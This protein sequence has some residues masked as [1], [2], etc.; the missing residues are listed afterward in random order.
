[1]RA[2]RRARNGDVVYLYLPLAHSFALLIQLI[3]ID[4]GGTVAYWGGDPKGVVGELMAVKPHYLPSV[5]RVFEKIY[6]LVTASGDPEKIKAATQ[7]GL[8]AR[9]LEA[10]GQPLPE[11][12]REHYEKADQ[13]LFANVRNVFGGQLRQATT[14]AAP[15]AKEI[16]EFFYACGVRCSRATA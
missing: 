1:M 4:L 12:L 6:T 7:L 5:P 2:D 11:A 13:E 14:G 15:I 9:A 8:K 16:L 3:A 10:A